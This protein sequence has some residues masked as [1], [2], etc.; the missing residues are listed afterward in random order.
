MVALCNGSSGNWVLCP[1]RWTESELQ[2]LLDEALGWSPCEEQKKPKHFVPRQLV[3]VS[4]KARVFRS[5]WHFLGAAVDGVT[6]AS[7][8]D[9]RVSVVPTAQHIEPIVIVE[10]R[11]CACGLRL[12]RAEQTHTEVKWSKSEGSASQLLNKPMAMHPTLNLSEAL[13]HRAC[14][15]ASTTLNPRL[16]SLWGF[17][18][19]RG[20]PTWWWCSVNWNTSSA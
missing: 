7:Y 1:S 3:G 4:S 5:L 11:A 20:G 15:Q 8:Y 17:R 19:S 6:R 13:K 9:D 12:K 10:S 2:I 18:C 16:G 14:T